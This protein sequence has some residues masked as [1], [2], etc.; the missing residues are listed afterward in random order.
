MYRSREGDLCQALPWTAHPLL[1]PPGPVVSG[2][3]Q[4][5]K[6]RRIVPLLERNAVVAVK[7]PFYCTTKNARKA[8]PL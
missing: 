5:R 7:L 3:Y 4:M 2:G 1:M 8:P 6:A